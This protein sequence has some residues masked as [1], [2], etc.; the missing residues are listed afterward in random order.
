MNQKC[1]DL[2]CSRN[3]QGVTELSDPAAG[4]L[5][6]KQKEGI[7]CCFQARRQALTLPV[8]GPSPAWSPACGGGRRVTRLGK[9][10]SSQDPE[11]ICFM[12]QALPP[13]QRVTLATS[14]LYSE[15]CCQDTSKIV[16]TVPDTDMLRYM[17][18]RY[19][20]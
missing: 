5:G 4:L 12:P 20:H 9:E 6:E 2:P 7:F 19:H 18:G 1:F 17:S 10:H 15:C 8:V 3:F 14:F 13:T 11:G 16:N